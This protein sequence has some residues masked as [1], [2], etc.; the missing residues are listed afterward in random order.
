[1][2]WIVRDVSR[3]PT[4]EWEVESRSEA[5]EKKDTALQLGANPE[6]IEIVPP[7]EDVEPEVV[8]Q[9][10]EAK[11]DGGAEVVDHPDP[12]PEEME[13]DPDII[14]SVDDLEQEDSDGYDLPD[15]PSV[16]EDPLTWMPE[17]FTDTIDG[18]VAI[19]R[20]GYEVMAHH[21]GIG[22]PDSECIVGPEETDY[23]FCR[24]KATAETEDGTVY[25]AHGSAHVDRGDDSYLLLEMADTR[26]RK[27]VIAQATGVGMVAVSELQNEVTGQ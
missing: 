27:R 1:M 19:N 9:T 15:K 6:N 20:K 13:N 18:T 3:D 17:D 22:T 7:S 26:A 25:T 5:E 12:S 21:Y 2:S 24:V 8:D 23:K 11:A 16:D 10:Q 14:T 4:K